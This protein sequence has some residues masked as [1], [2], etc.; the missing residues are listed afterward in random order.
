MN[1]NDFILQRNM[2]F[3][4]FPNLF[5]YQFWHWFSMSFGIVLHFGSLLAS[6][7]MFFRD[8]F[9]NVFWDGIF[10]GN[11][12]QMG[13]KKYPGREAFWLPFRDLLPRS[14]LSCILV[15]HWL[16][17]DILSTP[18]GS[19]LAPLRSLLAPFLS[20]WAFFGS[21]WLTFAHFGYLLVEIQIFSKMSI[22]FHGLARLVNSTQGFS[23][24]A[25]HH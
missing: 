15:A 23:C 13:V 10:N 24:S 19:L 21:L 4:D 18:S 2:I 14:T 7:F 16:T 9:L 12:S 20:L 11:E 8:R 5:R 22:N 1:F 3:D 17:F 25:W 6:M